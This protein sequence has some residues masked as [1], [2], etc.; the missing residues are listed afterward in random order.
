MVISVRRLSRLLRML[1]F[2]CLFSFI[3]Y[4]VLGLVQEMITPADKYREPIGSDAVKV[5][6][7]EPADADQVWEDVLA[8]LA[9]FY[10]IGE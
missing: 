6:T 10:Q 8:R 7:G 3:T 5:S 4:K 1:V 2:L 9:I